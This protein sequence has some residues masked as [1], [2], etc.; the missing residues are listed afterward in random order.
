MRIAAAPAVAAIAVVSPACT[1]PVPR[2]SI[3]LTLPLPS[4]PV[5]LLLPPLLPLPPSS[6][7]SPLPIPHSF[8]LSLFLSLVVAFLNLYTSLHCFPLRREFAFQ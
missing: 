4:L 6:T 3:S 8:P 2:P 7:N 5:L 1:F